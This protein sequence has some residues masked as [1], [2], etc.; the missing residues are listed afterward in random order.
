[1]TSPLPITHITSGVIA[2]PPSIDYWESIVFLQYT[3][4]KDKDGKEI[5]EGDIVKYTTLYYGKEKTHLTEVKWTD[6]I[7]NDSFGEPYTVGYAIYGMD[8][9][10]IGNIYENPDL[11]PKQG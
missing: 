9:E 10:V 7:E 2:A 11:L 4:L 8:W 3:G 1:M 6:N 5:Y